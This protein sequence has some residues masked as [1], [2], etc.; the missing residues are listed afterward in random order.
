[1]G[2]CFGWAIGGHGSESNV[3]RELERR[4]GLHGI[5][6]PYLIFTAPGILSVRGARQLDVRAQQRPCRPRSRT[7]CAG[8]AVNIDDILR[9]V[10]I[11][12]LASLAPQ[13][14]HDRL[15]FR[16]R[17]GS[18]GLMRRQGFFRPARQWNG[19]TTGAAIYSRVLLR[20]DCLAHE[21][22]QFK[23]SMGRVGSYSIQFPGARK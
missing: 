14:E 15:D 13:I 12:L 21:T 10:E 19:L 18:F 9:A 22:P 1:M 20:Y 11:F 8:R 23:V 3:S 4:A 7:S 16:R 5:Q 17:I 6:L 2:L